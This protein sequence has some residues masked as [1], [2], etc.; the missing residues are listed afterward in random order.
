M[1]GAE[2]SV[3]MLLL[4]FVINVAVLCAVLSGH[5]GSVVIKAFTDVLC[6]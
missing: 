3:A 1:S 6:P 5:F 2:T 4:L